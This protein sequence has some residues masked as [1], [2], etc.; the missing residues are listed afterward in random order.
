MLCNFQVAHSLFDF[1]KYDR[2][3]SSDFNVIFY[4]LTI[5]FYLKKFIR[6]RKNQNQVVLFNSIA[7]YHE[8]LNVNFPKSTTQE[9]EVIFLF[10]LY[11]KDL[12]AW[13][14]LQCYC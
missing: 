1:F 5:S 14:T 4:R 3:F 13:A 9:R 2:V 7:A 6:K 10:V 11:D 12:V 8:L